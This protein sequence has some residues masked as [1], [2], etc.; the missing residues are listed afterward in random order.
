MKASTFRFGLNLWPPFFF[1]S[2]RV[3]NISADYSEANVVLR[4]RPWNRNYV[5]YRKAI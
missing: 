1:N 5:R 2:I 3:Q 4:L